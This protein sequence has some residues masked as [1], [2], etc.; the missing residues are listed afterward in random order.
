VANVPVLVTAPTL[1]PVDIAEAKAYAR[2]EISDD[3]PL[4]QLLANAA[5][6][7]YE[8]YTG[9]TAVT[10]TWRIKLDSF[11]DAPW[12]CEE[13]GVLRLPRPPLQSVSSVAYLDSNEDSDT[14]AS[15]DYTVDTD[16]EPGRLLPAYGEDWPTTLD[17][18]N[19][20]TITFVAGYASVA[21]VPESVKLGMYYLIQHWYTVR[22]PVATSGAVPKVVPLTVQHLLNQTWHGGYR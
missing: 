9:R 6:R 17:H 18:P 13:E 16:S 14:W 2:V 4:F 7:F 21:L 5:R 12:Y 22:D 11:F 19:T 20:V 15:S 3:D 1:M 8:D 10:T